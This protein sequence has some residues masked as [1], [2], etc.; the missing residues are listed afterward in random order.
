MVPEGDL[1]PHNLRILGPIFELRHFPSQ[2]RT[3]TNKSTTMKQMDL[4]PLRTICTKK[5][6]FAVQS[7]TKSGTGPGCSGQGSRI[8]YR[9]EGKLRREH[10]A[11]SVLGHNSLVAKM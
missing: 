1:N 6:K 5:H 3:E 8:D 4:L 10:G 7:G 2:H 11:V 9:E